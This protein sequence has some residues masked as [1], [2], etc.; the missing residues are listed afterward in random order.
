MSVSR[1][2]DYRGPALFSYGFRPFF[3]FG[4][5]YAG[6]I[7]LMWLPVFYGRLQLS[8]AFAPRDW[9]VH[10]ML[11]GYI[12]AVVAGFL[13]TAVPNWTGRLPLQGRP[14]ILLF[15]TWVAGRIAVSFSAWIGWAPAA[16]IDSVFL[17]LLA[18]SAAREIIAGKKWGNLMIVAIISLLAAGNL[19]FH[20]EAHFEGLAEYTTRG[21]I[22]VVISLIAL[23][24]GRII[25]SFTR[26][27][28]AKRTPGQMPAP[29]GRFDVATIALS[30][31]VLLF[32]VVRPLDR[33]TG[34]LLLVC[35][36][37]HLIRLVRWTGYRTFAD[38][39]VL[40]LHVAY[41]FVPAGFILTALSAF[42]LVAPSAGIHAWTGGAIGTMTLAVMSRATLGHTGQR[43]QAS[44]ATQLIYAAVIIAALARVCAV[45]ETD[46]TGPLLVAAG[47]AWAA[48]FLGFA[49]IY[50]VAFWSPRRH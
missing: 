48:A 39:L 19:A 45:L 33:T 26:N 35:G 32:W 5:V 31:L 1:L 10:E 15:S 44:P 40:I 28:L 16:A 12:A 38:R 11:F 7:I 41:A 18:A 23:I 9:H 42:D 20:L 17:I 30:V 8:T 36:G 2:R 6:A 46:H 43:L 34:G 37:M 27:W 24:G 25:P 22:A 13:L 29:F 3:F 14:L 47:I 49:A 50:S 21:G 4:S